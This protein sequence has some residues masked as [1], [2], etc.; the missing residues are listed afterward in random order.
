[1]NWVYVK[2]YCICNNSPSR[3][4]LDFFFFWGYSGAFDVYMRATKCTNEANKMKREK[5]TKTIKHSET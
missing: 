2:S 3:L 4:M 1:M 5:K